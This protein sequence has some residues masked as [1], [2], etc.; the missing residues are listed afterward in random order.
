MTSKLLAAYQVYDCLRLQYSGKLCVSGLLSGYM[1]RAYF[2][3]AASLVQSY[4]IYLVSV[5][6]GRYRV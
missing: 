1:A 2:K 4:L 3:S 5:R 6:L